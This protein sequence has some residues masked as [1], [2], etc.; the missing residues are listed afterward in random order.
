MLSCASWSR[1]ALVHYPL[2]SCPPTI[3]SSAPATT[4]S[5]ASTAWWSGCAASTAR[6]CWSAPPRRPAASRARRPV[7]AASPLSWHCMPS[8]AWSSWQPPLRSS[9][10]PMALATGARRVA[11]CRGGLCWFGGW[12]RKCPAPSNHLSLA[13]PASP[14][15]SATSAKFV[16]GSVRL[17]LDK[18]EGGAAWLQGLRTVPYEGEAQC[19]RATIRLLRM[20]TAVAATCLDALGIYRGAFAAAG[21]TPDLTPLPGVRFA[22][23]CMQRR[24][25]RCARCRAP[26]Q[27]WP[28]VSASSH[29]TSTRRSQVGVP[30]MSG[31]CCGSGGCL[32]LGVCPRQALPLTLCRLPPASSPAVDTHGKRRGGAFALRLWGFACKDTVWHCVLP[33]RR[34]PHH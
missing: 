7:P 9:C 17:L 20:P 28:P 11:E 31:L 19:W 21:A 10:A 32:A 12:C 15:P 8:P 13:P 5:H 26:A 3:S 14:L 29:S 1:P 16:T 18:P 33:P 27:R 2:L 23:L 24:P 34:H 6:R 30:C 4:I 25:R 22:S